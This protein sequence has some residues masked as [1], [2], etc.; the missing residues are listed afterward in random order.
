MKRYSNRLLDMQML[1][2]AVTWLVLLHRMMCH[3]YF[4][5]CKIV[6]NIVIS[7]G[8]NQFFRLLLL[9]LLE[10]RDE[11]VLI[12]L[13]IAYARQRAKKFI[14]YIIYIKYKIIVTL[15]SNFHFWIILLIMYTIQ[16]KNIDNV[17]QGSPVSKTT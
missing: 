12:V 16:V 1:N 2:I 9:L 14:I 3:M 17:F 13:S 6:Q 5:I 8:F 10:Y 15:W 11:F 7:C 4:V